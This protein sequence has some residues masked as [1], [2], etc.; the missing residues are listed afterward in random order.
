[1][2]RSPLTL[3]LLAAALPAGA[4]EPEIWGED[5][6]A[7]V[8]P[9]IALAATPDGGVCAI[10]E[11]GATCF[12]RDGA[13]RAQLDLPD[14]DVV[15]AVGGTDALALLTAGG[16]V[17][18]PIG[19][20]PTVRLDPT[21]FVVTREDGALA[22]VGG[23][24]GAPIADDFPMV[25]ALVTADGRVGAFDPA[26]DLSWIDGEGAVLSTVRLGLPLDGG[27]RALPVDRGW[28]VLHDAGIALLDPDGAPRGGAE[29]ALRD[30]AVGPDRL[31]ATD[32]HDI[33]SIDPENGQ[34]L[35]VEADV[36]ATALAA[37]GNRLYAATAEGGR[38]YAWERGRPIAD[39]GHR[40]PILRL[41]PVGDGGVASLDVA[42]VAIRWSSRGEPTALGD[43]IVDVAV[44]GLGAAWTLGL[45]GTTRHLGKTKVE[46][47]LQGSAAIG[48]P[49]GAL[50]LT[51]D[52]A[53]RLAPDGSERWRVAAPLG[54]AAH[55]E[56]VVVVTTDDALAVH[57][58]TTGARRRWITS[59]TATFLA[60]GVAVG[61]LVAVGR[62]PDGLSFGRPPVLPP[63]E[64]RP[65]TDGPAPA[66]SPNGRFFAVATDEGDVIVL[67]A[68]GVALATVTPRGAP[69]TLAFD[70][71][72][73]WIGRFDGRIE[74]WDL[75]AAVVDAPLPAFD[76][77]AQLE[78]F[79]PA[80]AAGP[81]D[82]ES[83]AGG[84]RGL[85][86][87]A[88]GRLVLHVGQVAIREPSGALRVLPIEDGGSPS[89][90]RA[91]P[92]R[93]LV[94]GLLDG[95]VLVDADADA[96]RHAATLPAPVTDLCVAGDRLLAATDGGVWSIPED[97]PATRAPGAPTGPVAALACAPDGRWAAALVDGR[98]VVWEVE[99]GAALASPRQ[100]GR[101][102]A[103][104]ATR[105]GLLTGGTD[106]V[107]VAWEPRRWTVAGLLE[108]H[109]APIDVVA[110]LPDDRHVAV[111]AGGRALV[112]DLDSG[113]PLRRV[114][115]DQPV[116]AAV[117]LPDGRVVIGGLRGRIVELQVVAP[118]PPAPDG[119]APARPSP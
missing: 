22:F 34:I 33:F 55:A 26:G 36:P 16:A 73:L 107:V 112:W 37:V 23:A 28:A 70:A 35:D 48:L 42:G 97:R 63:R 76:G 68:D 41:A 58:A 118:T 90:V 14:G 117:P 51:G 67:G 116:T 103:I 10:D 114:D 19:G 4:A 64:I 27:A 59:D 110:A 66:L 5:A 17:L 13:P 43:E 115:L 38:L 53:V 109:G 8:A 3:C 30:V 93:G 94:V 72:Y 7:L 52:D 95:R 100:G 86:A 82:A 20:G 47:S 111:G 106:E 1:M 98:A 75:T 15:G 79:V 105:S 108:G 89:V 74:R 49:D 32:G 9:P 85:A 6:F 62:G 57:D 101:I 119:P 54:A 25:G 56:G 91:L 46:T 99:T 102:T 113:R 24:D 31:Y 2:R 80:P 39:G 104:A 88:D 50:V 87:T 44:D 77:Y 12:D 18:A 45:L 61:G 11:A 29:V 40:A 65:A 21:T 92:G 60:G 84:V 69:T 96:P 78:P 81:P 71:R 83:A